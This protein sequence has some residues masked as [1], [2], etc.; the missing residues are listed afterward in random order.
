MSLY[1]PGPCV[2]LEAATPPLVP[3]QCSHSLAL[4]DLEANRRFFSKMSLFGKKK[5]LQFWTW[6]LMVNHGE[7]PRSAEKNVLL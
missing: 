7:D 4:V 3:A 5:E 2:P 6:D 1:F